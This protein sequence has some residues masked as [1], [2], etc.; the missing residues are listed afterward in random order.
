M[1]P[2]CCMLTAS[3]SCG[4]EA[5]LPQG[6]NATGPSLS[7]HSNNTKHGSRLLACRLPTNQT[8]CPTKKEEHLNR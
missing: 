8:S 7:H 1:T 3:I 2:A 6:P 4:I 5:S